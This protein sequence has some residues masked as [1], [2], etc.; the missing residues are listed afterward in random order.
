MN[1]TAFTHFQ[2]KR[3]GRYLSIINGGLQELPEVLMVGQVLV[4]L[5]LPAVYPLHQYNIIYHSKLQQ[6]ILDQYSIYLPMEDKDMKECVQKENSVWSDACGVQ[7]NRLQKAELNTVILGSYIDPLFPPVT[8]S[9]SLLFSSSSPYSPTIL[10]TT[11]EMWPHPYIQATC[12]SIP[13][14]CGHL[15]QVPRVVT[16]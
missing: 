12:M 15:L 3:V 16:N 10:I 7:Q 5:L 13:W 14:L 9:P 6:S 8:S 4:P 11:T 1:K 2:G